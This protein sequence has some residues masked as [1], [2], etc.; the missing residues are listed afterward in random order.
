MSKK[1]CENFADLLMNEKVAITL[2]DD[3]SNRKLNEILTNNDFF[4]KA[5]Q[6]IEKTFALGTGTFVISTDDMRATQTGKILKDG[7]LKI[8]FVNAHN[9]YPLTFDENDITECAFTSYLA[10]VDPIKTAKP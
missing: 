9:I 3:T 1:I 4:V 7:K 5:N 8:Q 6:G 2:G 10:E